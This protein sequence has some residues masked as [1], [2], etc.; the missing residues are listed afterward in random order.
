[1]G[2]AKIVVAEVVVVN[3]VIVH[4]VVVK[5]VQDRLCDSECLS[6]GAIQSAVRTVVFP[7]VWYL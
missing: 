5:V 1:M 7:S 2:T 4:V 3:V 6:H